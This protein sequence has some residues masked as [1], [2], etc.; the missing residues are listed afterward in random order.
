DTT[1]IVNSGATL[2]IDGI[3]LSGN[4]NAMALQVAGRVALDRVNIHSN[5]G[6]AIIASDDS[7]ELLIR[8]S[9]IAANGNTNQDAITLTGGELTILYSSL[10]G[11]G[12]ASS[13]AITCADGDVTV[14]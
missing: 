2:L 7:A 4:T 14:R 6:G 1:M 8:T 9:I 3:N 10:T 5:N 11:V 13:Q 12:S